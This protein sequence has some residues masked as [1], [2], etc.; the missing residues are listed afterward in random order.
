MT[1]V[2]SILV[3]V[4]LFKVR[5]QE[6]EAE[7]EVVGDREAKERNRIDQENRREPNRERIVRSKVEIKKNKNQLISLFL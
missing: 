1:C 3:E 4:N 6:D 2:I 7:P 5:Y